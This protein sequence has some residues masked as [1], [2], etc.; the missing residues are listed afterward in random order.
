M[1]TMLNQNPEEVIT[2]HRFST[3]SSNAFKIPLLLKLTDTKSKIV[4]M[5]SSCQN[6]DKFTHDGT[7]KYLLIV[8][9]R[10]NEM[11]FTKPGKCPELA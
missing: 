1:R 2:Q 5:I 10:K 7:Y 8:H 9:L 6:Q 4:V 11:E 3:S